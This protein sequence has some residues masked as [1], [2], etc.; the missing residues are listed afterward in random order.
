MKN[1]AF[2]SFLLFITTACNAQIT[3]TITWTEKTKLT[4]AN[5]IYYNASKKLIWADFK[6]TPDKPDPTAAI[7][8][9]GFG[10]NA[11]MRSKNG[12]GTINVD[13]YCYFNKPNSWV[14]KGKN[15]AYILNHEQHHFDAT[16][17]IA[18]TFITRVKEAALT[19]DNM[20]TELARIYKDC[21]VLLNKMQD[22]Y[23]T[24]T[25]N[26]IDKA[27]QANWDEIFKEKLLIANK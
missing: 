7:T 20:N 17:I 16:Y 27:K 9:S 10:Y 5:V 8:S 11:G 22:D 15:T 1:T 24:Q 4:A 19:P 25:R 23:D 2:F 26:G 6:G 3:T 13:I 21:N 18:K 12:K 14:K